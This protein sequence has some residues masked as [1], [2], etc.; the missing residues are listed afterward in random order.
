MEINALDA[1]RKTLARQI[2]DLE[3]SSKLTDEKRDKWMCATGLALNS[4]KHH[5][6]YA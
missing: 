4:I 2:S 1:P 3:Q 6:N 5:G